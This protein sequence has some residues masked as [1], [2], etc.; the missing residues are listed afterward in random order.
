[1]LGFNPE[2][3]PCKICF[4]VFHVSLRDLN[5][6]SCRPSIWMRL[7]EVLPKGARVAHAIW[8]P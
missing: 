1:M 7:T 6:Q 2:I 8:A 4:K 3:G 5:S